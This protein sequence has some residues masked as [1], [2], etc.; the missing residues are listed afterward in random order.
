M[1]CAD[2]FRYSMDGGIA[3]AKSMNLS[4]SSSCLKPR[5]ANPFPSAMSLSSAYAAQSCARII[6]ASSRT[7]ATAPLVITQRQ[8]NRRTPA[9]RWESTASAPSSTNPK[10]S[11]IVEQISQLTLLETADLVS[12]LKVSLHVY[13][14]RDLAIHWRPFTGPNHSH[15]TN[16]GPV[17]SRLNIP[18]MPMGSFAAGPA[19][20]AAAAAPVEEEVAAPAAQEK[21][22]FT[23]TLKS[24]DAA[25]KPK[26]IKE[27]KSM[28]GLSLVDSKK[29]VEG[30]PKQ[31][32]EGVPKEES[33]KI[34]ESM[35]A[36]GAVVTMD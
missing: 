14:I 32:K 3:L 20:P 15:C 5:A 11:T 34:I 7:N 33:E 2:S 31:M 24:F 35:K 18:D 25:A 8:R 12:N 28:L 22:L 10:I 17:Q 13:W 29:F 36:L 4:T 30:A 16:L 21:T 23:L 27:I 19:A 1:R 6:R 9:R 26:V